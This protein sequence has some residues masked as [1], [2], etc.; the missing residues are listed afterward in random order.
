[1][2]D[3]II[4]YSIEL[5]GR[6]GIKGVTM[7]AIASEAGISKRTLYEQFA[8][9]EQLLEACL[10]SRLDQQ[11]L[12][13]LT[14]KSPIDELLALYAGMRRLDLKRA[15]HFCRE[16]RKFHAP[17]YELLHRKLLDYASACGKHVEAGIREGYIRRDVQ[18]EMVCTAVSSCMT[19]LFAY[20]DSEYTDIR[21][22]LSPN[23]V[24]VFARGICTIK[25]RNYLEQKIKEI[26]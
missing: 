21:R 9:K 23:I 26:A 6:Y 7:D 10:C 19:R 13:T 20:P 17:V 16:L 4:N 12:F 1:M 2:K 8:C 11:R 25:G 15:R 14:G 24:V 5:F 22:V 18:P 3:R